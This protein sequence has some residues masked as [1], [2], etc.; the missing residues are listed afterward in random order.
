MEG[1]ATLAHEANTPSLTK[2]MPRKVYIVVVI[3]GA[4]A[5]QKK[6]S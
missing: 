4:N 6:G 2:M 3:R 5:K 1:R